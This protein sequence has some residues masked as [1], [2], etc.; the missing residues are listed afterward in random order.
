M[1]MAVPLPVELSC[2]QAT[3]IICIA[4]DILFI[5]FHGGAYEGSEPRD[6][7]EQDRFSEGNKR[8]V[9]YMLSYVQFSYGLEGEMSFLRNGRSGGALKGSDHRI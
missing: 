8:P 9:P 1:G 7:S 3:P 4:L 2:P 5:A 6:R